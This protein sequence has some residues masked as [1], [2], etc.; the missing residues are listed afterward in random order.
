MC[1]IFL[2]A[3]IAIGLELLFIYRMHLGPDIYTGKIYCKRRGYT[4][5]IKKDIKGSIL[6]KNKPWTQIWTPMR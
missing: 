5:N 1:R 6:G 4:D 2:L 3:N